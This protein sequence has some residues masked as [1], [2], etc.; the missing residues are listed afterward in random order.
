MQMDLR[1]IPPNAAQGNRNQKWRI[2]ALLVGWVLFI[3]GT[4]CTVIRPLEFFELIRSVTGF[5]HETLER[6]AVFWGGSWFTIVKGWH[7]T[8]FAILTYLCE[9]VLKWWIGS[10]SPLSILAAMAFS[11]LF[12]ASDEWHQTFVPDRFGTVQDVL[13]DSLGVCAAGVTLLVSLRRN[14]QKSSPDRCID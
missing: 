4:S 5:Q 9:R 11:L 12:A 3:F 2:A 10:S 14:E 8:E 7:F 13:I 6:F 1:T